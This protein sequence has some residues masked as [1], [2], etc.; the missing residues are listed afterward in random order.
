MDGDQPGVA[1]RTSEA[2]ESWP[3]GLPVF[4]LLTPYPATPL[5]DRLRNENR[6]TRP[7]HWLDFRPFRMAFTP[8]NMS[9]EQAESEVRQAWTRS[10]DAAAVAK[11]LSRIAH[12]PY[13]ERAVLLFTRLLFRGIYFPQM[14]KRHWIKVLFSY[15]R[16]IIQILREG[17]TAH[18]VN[19]RARMLATSASSIDSK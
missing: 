8:R 18:R 17:I 19:G 13:K 6:L 4:G 7:Q 14:R 9:I 11:A 12:R 2:I 15:R 10:Y 1:A 5:Y 3:P 16:S